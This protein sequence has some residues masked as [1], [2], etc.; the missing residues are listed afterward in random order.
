MISFPEVNHKRT[1]LAV[2]D[3]ETFADDFI[4]NHFFEKRKVVRFKCFKELSKYLEES[5]N[6]R[7]KREQILY[8]IEDVG[9]GDKKCVLTGTMALARDG[10]IAELDSFEFDFSFYFIN[11]ESRLMQVDKEQA[12]A[13][14]RGF[15][16]SRLASDKNIYAQNCNALDYQ[17]QY[18]E[19]V[20]FGEK[21]TEKFRQNQNE[22]NRL[23][24]ESEQEKQPVSKKIN[25]KK[26]D[27]FEK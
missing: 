10:K 5:E 21:V 9:D 20:K 27:N 17:N 13:T 16:K 22:L 11:V 23:F 1:D 14:W 3:Y 25:G 2:R 6:F 26:K 19:F 7:G 18:N 8:I 15:V 4:Y 24:K 12:K